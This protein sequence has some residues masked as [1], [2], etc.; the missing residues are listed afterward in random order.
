MLSYVASFEGED[1]QRVFRF[2]ATFSRW[3]YVLKSTG[4]AKRG[5][6]GQAEA[7]WNRYADMVADSVADITAPDYVAARDYILRSPPLQWKFEDGWQPNPRRPNETEM[8][9]LLRVVR[10]VRN[11]LFHG[12][13]FHG[14]PMKELARDR[15]LIDAATTILET[16][17]DLRPEMRRAFD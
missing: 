5:S 12:G 17:C 10:D 15:Q 13:K 6:H 2:L 1:R 9:Y 11:N 3:E 7:D 8:R 4:Y 16:C 14:G